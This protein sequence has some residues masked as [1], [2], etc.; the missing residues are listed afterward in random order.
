MADYAIPKNGVAY[1]FYGCLVSQADT[2]LFKSAP[3]LAAGDF[4]VSIDGGAFANLTTLPT[5]TPGTFSVKFSLSAAEMTGDNILVV[6]S[7]AAG[8]E[9]C[10]QCW[11]IQTSARGIADLAYPATSGRSMVVDAS[12]LVDANVVKLGPSG[13]GT[14]Q[15]ARDIGAS[16]ITASGT[17]TTVTNQLTAAQIATGV[18]QDATAGDFT[19]ANSIGK[20][21]MNGVALGTGLTIAAVS[22][23][24]GSVTGA[25]GSVT[26]AVGSVTGNLSGSVGSIAIG[27]IAAASFA[28]DAIDATALAATAA[29][30]I[31][32]AVWAKA[33]A[34]LTGDPGATPTVLQAL[35]LPYMAI[36]NLRVTDSGGGT[37][38][39]CNSAGATIL[40][41]SITDAAS[42]FT[43][44]KYA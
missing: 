20:S 40:T 24:V 41:A 26:G 33:E 28:A 25:V 34:E 7:D 21:V 4:K 43:K 9:W 36:R 22:G 5:N 17:V 11:N 42:I 2:K 32:D 31:R 27:G 6:A 18:W 13:S 1:I 23:A 3:T 37:D 15:T 8:A 38:T 39:I 30:E 29:N 10:D 12:G 16:V 44:A 14:A 19:A 35:M